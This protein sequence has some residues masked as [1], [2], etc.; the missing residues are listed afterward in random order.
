M[1][2]FV[3]EF[4]NLHL[5]LL[6]V[7]RPTSGTQ[8]SFPSSSSHPAS[9]AVDAETDARSPVFRYTLVDQTYVT[10]KDL[11]HNHVRLPPGHRIPVEQ[12]D[13][14]GL[15]HP[16][17]NPIGWTSVPCSSDDDGNSIHHRRRIAIGPDA[18]T[19][20]RL[21]SPG[22]VVNFRA[23]SVSTDGACRQYSLAALFGK[24]IVTTTKNR[25]S[26]FLLTNKLNIEIRDTSSTYESP[27]LCNFLLGFGY[28]RRIEGK[29]I[30]LSVANVRKNT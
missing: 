7:W 1:C 21:L 23:A 30:N 3:H 19:T 4:V 2:L 11:R 29:Q 6:K 10:P 14:L 8:A 15:Y 25:I 27:D 26:F 5:K 9:D 24:T 22:D 16:G 18:A 13:V 12:G 28:L 17:Y 20:G